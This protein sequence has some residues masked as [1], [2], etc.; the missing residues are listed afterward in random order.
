MESTEIGPEG[1]QLPDL[2]LPDEYRRIGYMV[3]RESGQGYR[4]FG[5][6]D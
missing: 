4:H 5:D 6:P 2:T 3:A 1:P